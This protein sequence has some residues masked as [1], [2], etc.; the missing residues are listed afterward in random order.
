MVKSR[1]TDSHT[2]EKIFRAAT[3]IFE[4]KGYAAA[5]MQEI[6]DRAGINKALLHYYFTTKE[7]LF[8]AVFQLLKQFTSISHVAFTVATA[9][10]F[11]TSNV[12]SMDSSN[13]LD[14]FSI[15]FQPSC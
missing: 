2:R 10:K 4:E 13:H 14:F 1:I 11:S 7:Q 9:T 8:M 5:R 3:E 6:A 15:S 12:P